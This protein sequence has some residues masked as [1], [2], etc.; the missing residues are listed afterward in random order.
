MLPEV[1][2]GANDARQIAATDGL[3]GYPEY[4]RHR[5]SLGFG[6]GRWWEDALAASMA[7]KRRHV[8]AIHTLKSCHT[9]KSRLQLA[10]E[11]VEK[12]P[13]RIVGDDLLRG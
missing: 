11:L 2:E 7:R 10:F 13:I 1:R 5:W 9:R 3:A 8:C 4:S 6:A 12:S